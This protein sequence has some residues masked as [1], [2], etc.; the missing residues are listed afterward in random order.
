MTEYIQRYT[1]STYYICK[2]EI[3]SS[4]VATCDFFHMDSESYRD[5]HDYD[6][7][8]CT[9]LTV[10]RLELYVNKFFD[11]HILKGSSLESIKGCG[12]IYNTIELDL[13]KAYFNELIEHAKIKYNSIDKAIVKYFQ[14]VQFKYDLLICFA[15]LNNNNDDVLQVIPII[16]GDFYDEIIQVLS[17]TGVYVKDKVENYIK[18][19]K[20]NQIC[21]IDKGR[22]QELFM[23]IYESYN[24]LKKIISRDENKLPICR[25]FDNTLF[26]DVSEINFENENID[27]ELSKL[28]LPNKQNVYSVKPNSEETT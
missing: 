20:K 4:F 27:N 3:H 17:N 12:A 9:C 24:I 25:P 19:C 6:S 2:T 22:F 28:P 15:A 8:K 13:N 21:G 10:K 14:N 18:S 26:K 11:K 16:Y 5:T 23:R 1:V 7:G